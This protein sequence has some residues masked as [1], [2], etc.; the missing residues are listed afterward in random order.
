M[1]EQLKSTEMKRE[2]QDSLKDKNKLRFFAYEFIGT[3][4]LTWGY[5]MTDQSNVMLLMLTLMSWEVSC[6]HFN[7]SISLGNVFFHY[8]DIKN[9]LAPYLI[10]TVV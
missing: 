9:N 4:L 6:A 2:L 3:A 8:D 7:N 1:S 5:N 10:L